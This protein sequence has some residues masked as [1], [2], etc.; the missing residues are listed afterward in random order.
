MSVNITSV[1][2]KK[3][4]FK[5]KTKF[6]LMLL[7]FAYAFIYLNE[8]QREIDKFHPLVHFTDG[9]N[10]HYAAKPKLVALFRFPQWYLGSRQ[11]GLLLLFF[12]AQLQ[13][14]GSEVSSKDIDWYLKGMLASQEVVFPYNWDFKLKKIHK[15]WFVAR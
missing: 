12:Q 14:A 6:A 10:G 4:M 8:L 9:W 13:G 3:K 2:N 11:L 5:A 7:I 15:I 1:K